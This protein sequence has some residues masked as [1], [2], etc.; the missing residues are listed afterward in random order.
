MIVQIGHLPIPSIKN[1]KIPVIFLNAESEVDVKEVIEKA[2]PSLSGEKIGVV[3]TAQHVH[4]VKEIQNI[5][6]ENGFE[7]VVS[8]GDNRIEAK[9]QILGCNFSAATQISDNVDMFLFVGSG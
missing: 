6:V 3:T 8:S 5:L 7:P 1:L 2:I 9:G 4:K